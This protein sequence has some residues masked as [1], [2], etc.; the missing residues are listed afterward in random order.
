MVTTKTLP[1]YI[2]SDL[3]ILFIGI[4]PGTRSAEVGHHYAGPSN[5]FWKLLNEAKLVPCVVTYQDDWRLPEWGLGLT[6][7][8]SRT[9][10]GSSG[11]AKPDYVTGRAALA[12]KVRQ[13]RPRILALLGIT[14][15]PILFPKR[16][17][18]GERSRKRTS[19]SQVG[20][21]PE[22]FEGAKV[23][24]LPNP[25]GR[26]AHYSYYDM[27]IGFRELKHVRR[28]LQTSSHSR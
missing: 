4:N 18:S 8:V 28:S 26:N 23:V 20:L 25:S 21:L 1:D 27:L 16:L 22:S 2:K 24:L 19:K 17:L 6:N 10:S 9:T 14:L 11:L 3:D 15:Y 5:R 13:Y 12:D 7:V